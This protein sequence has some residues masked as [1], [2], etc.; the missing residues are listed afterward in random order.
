MPF[1]RGNRF[2]R[3]GRQNPPGGRPSNAE[4]AAKQE[5]I[6]VAL[7]ML[8]AG[9]GKAVQTLL[10]HLD[11]DQE[12]VSLRAAQSLIDYALR[13]H[14]HDELLARIEALERIIEQGQGGYR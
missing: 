5:M 10:R 8:K 4:R 2:G 14:E 13:T 6:R 7:D 9:M 12:S 11:S 3:G 1:E